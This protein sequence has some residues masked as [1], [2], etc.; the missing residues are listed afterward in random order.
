MK[1]NVKIAGIIL[2][3]LLGA[4]GCNYVHRGIRGFYDRAMFRRH[5]RAMEFRH[6]QRMAYGNMCYGDHFMNRGPR[7]FMNPDGWHRQGPGMRE[8]MSQGYGMRGGRN[9]GQAGWADRRM[10]PPAQGRMDRRFRMIDRIPNLTD[11]QRKDIADIRQ[12]QAEQMDKIRE[13]TFSKMQNI[14]EDGRSEIM[15]LLTDEQKKFLESGPQYG[16]QENQ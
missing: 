9:I 7:H 6:H 3:V 15:N 5:Y 14:R 12:K 8:G 13:E 2:V 1:G 16:R 4:T 11:K 10:N